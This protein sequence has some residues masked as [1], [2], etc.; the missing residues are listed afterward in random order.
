M[1]RLRTPPRARA[2]LTLA[3]A[4]AL[5]GCAH[6]IRVG[7]SRNLNLALSEY[8][9]TPDTVRAYSG[10][11]TI[12]VHNVGARTHDLAITQGSND[13]ALTPDL[14]PG[15]TTLMTV[16]LAPGKYMLRSKITGDQALG[17][18]GTLDVVDTHRT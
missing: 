10:T 16:N 1:S 8:R 4:W 7:S 17:L 5:A 11:L 13:V 18:W 12:T 2:V 15:Q 6:T 9:V 3:L 14:M